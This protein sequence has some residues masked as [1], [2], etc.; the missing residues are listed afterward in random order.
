MLQNPPLL[1]ADEALQD[2]FAYLSAADFPCGPGERLRAC[3]VFNLT[4]GKQTAKRLKTRLCPI[5]ARSEIDQLRFYDAY[6]LFFGERGLEEPPGPRGEKPPL[7]KPKE[8]RRSSLS[9]LFA[10]LKR[11]ARKIFAICVVLSGSA[12]LAYFN[13]GGKIQNYVGSKT[14]P[15]GQVDVISRPPSQQSV[16]SERPCKGLE[17]VTDG[18]RLPLFL[19]PLGLCVLAYL[20]SQTQLSR[21][22]RLAAREKNLRPPFVWPLTRFTP[23]LSLYRGLFNQTAEAMRVRLA[24]D[25]MELDLDKTIDATIRRAGFPVFHLRP[26]SKPPEYLFLIQQQNAA[27]HFACWWMEIANRLRRLGVPIN[28]YVYSSDLRRCRLQNSHIAWSTQ[29]LFDS[30]ERATVLLFGSARDLLHRFSGEFYSWIDASLIKR[31]R[32]ALMLSKASFEWAAPERKVATK[33][34]VVPARVA[35][36][37]PAV[38]AA[39][40]S[41][42]RSQESHEPPSIPACYFDEREEDSPGEPPSLAKFLDPDVYQWLCACAVHP[43]LEWELTLHL[44]LVVAHAQS[45]PVAKVFLLPPP[46]DFAALQRDAIEAINS[47]GSVC[48]PFVN[49]PDNH[50]D[51]GR[52]LRQSITSCDVCIQL[53]DSHSSDNLTQQTNSSVDAETIAANLHKPY[54]IFSPRGRTRDKPTQFVRHFEDGQDLR[55]KISQALADCFPRPR[56]DKIFDER[57]LLQLI[58]LPWFR[59]GEIPGAWR[60]WLVKQLKPDAARATRQLLLDALESNRAPEGSFARGQQDLYIQ[61][62]RF[63]LDQSSAERRVDLENAINSMPVVDVKEDFLLHRLPQPLIPGIWKL[64]WRRIHRAGV[65]FGAAGLGG[66]L[67]VGAAVYRMPVRGWT[68]PPSTNNSAVLPAENFLPVPTCNSP[69]SAFSTLLQI[70][71]A[72]EQT[73]KAMPSGEGR[74]GRMSDLIGAASNCARFSKMESLKSFFSDFGVEKDGLRIVALGLAEANPSGQFRLAVEAIRNSRSPFEQYHGLMLAQLLFDSLSD[75]EKLELRKTIKSQI[76]G[77]ITQDDMTRWQPAE[78]LLSR[79]SARA[80]NS[81]LR[82]TNSADIPPI[83]RAA[84]GTPPYRWTLSGNLPTGF[85]FDP[86]TGVISG[87]CQTP[88]VWNV[89]VT[90]TDAAGVTATEAAAVNCPVEPAQSAPVIDFKAL[91]ITYLGA[92]YHN[93]G[94]TIIVNYTF[95]GTCASCFLEATLVFG[96]AGKTKLNDRLFLSAKTMQVSLSVSQKELRQYSVSLPTEVDICMVDNSGKPFF[97]KQFPFSFSPGGSTNPNAQRGIQSSQQSI[98]PSAKSVCQFYGEANQGASAWNKDESC[99]IPQVDSL[100]TNYRQEDFNCC[101][102]G[103]SSQATGR[104]IPPGL[105]LKVSGGYY[106]SVSNPRLVDGVFYLQTYCGPEPFPGPG[107]NVKV[108]VL[109]HYLRTAKE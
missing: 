108:E 66:M 9:S 27:D 102:G 95:G 20:L 93:L 7:P 2:F 15:Q 37:M 52:F 84:G 22:F 101:G 44:G 75:T 55:S 78:N 68:L 12:V 88:G 28:T 51:L 107:C 48:I 81:P 1:V 83:F 79:L 8:K 54:L 34:P 86:S 42:F 29:L 24:G 14:P 63:W 13:V 3:K 45:L 94:M 25:E 35:N 85:T 65:R 56:L 109:A 76:G 98:D 17:C 74:T 82:I 32:R 47:S 97:C 6:E 40:A 104:D 80:S 26:R 87:N 70:A 41:I 46:P 4:Q 96:E 71:D 5:F 57:K 50:A 73:R 59:T 53:G 19:A 10:Y 18:I 58:R 60:L 30:F 33:L 103:A 105:E 72:Y 106:W 23:S 61:A 62:H 31:E 90:V 16:P 89:R 21:R 36:I 38:G 69:D 64:R 49:V 77:T 99:L 92:T 11:N 67:L 91:N 39:T 43:K 100:D